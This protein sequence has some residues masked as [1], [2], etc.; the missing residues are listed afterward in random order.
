MANRLVHYDAALLRRFLADSFGG[1]GDLLLLALVATLGTFW[2]R[3]QMLAAPPDAVWFALLAG[4]IG[5]AVH[6]MGHRRLTD[7]SEH[8]PAAPAALDGRARR[9]W[10]TLAHLLLWLPLLGAALLLGLATGRLWL[11]VTL[12]AVGYAAGAAGATLPPVQRWSGTMRSSRPSVVP[13]GSGRHAVIAL[14]LARQTL[15][16]R[17][18]VARAGLLLLISFLLTVVAAWGGRGLPAPLGLVL[19][20]L[21]S[22]V[23]LLLATRLDAALLA[24]LPAA[25]YRP[26]FIALAVSALPLASLLAATGALLFTG[27]DGGPVLVLA[28]AHLAFILIGIARAW[29]YPGRTR[30]SVDVQ[31]QLEAI[32]LVAVAI[33]LPPLAV[34]AAGW[35]FWHFYTLCRAKAWMQA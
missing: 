15:G 13:L 18:P 17:R 10:L 33:L 4:P 12:A 16:S 6:R 21:P 2:L 32:G 9:T 35:R 34:A 20:L 30:R 27:R 1:I 8:S 3:Q 29:L 31:L 14:V 5:F 23:M 11:A 22:L 19:P 25:G 7:L 26:G 24:F 28:L